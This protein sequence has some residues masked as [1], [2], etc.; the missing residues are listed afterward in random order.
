MGFELMRPLHWQIEVQ[1]RDP[2]VSLNLSRDKDNLNWLTYWWLT[3]AGSSIL[4]P[5]SE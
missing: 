3:I 2:L 1:C 5:N 4:F